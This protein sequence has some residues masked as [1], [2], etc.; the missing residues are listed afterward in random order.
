MTLAGIVDILAADAGHEV[1][2]DEAPTTPGDLVIQQG[3]C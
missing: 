3:D 1:R 2:G